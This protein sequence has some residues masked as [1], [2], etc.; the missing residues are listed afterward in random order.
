[1]WNF[2]AA[3]LTCLILLAAQSATALPTPILITFEGL[4]PFVSPGSAIPESWCHR[5]AGFSMRQ[6]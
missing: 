1:M 4:T 2:V 6:R 5:R 3:S